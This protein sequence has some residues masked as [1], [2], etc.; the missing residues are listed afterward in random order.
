[1]KNSSRLFAKMARN[2]TRSRSGFDSSRASSSTRRLK[3]SQEISR[4]KNRGS[5]AKTSFRAPL[6]PA[7]A[8]RAALAAG[9][10]F[11][12]P[13]AS[14]RDTPS[15]GSSSPRA[16]IGFSSEAPTPPLPSKV[17]EGRFSFAS[18][19]MVPLSSG[20]PSFR[21]LPTGALYPLV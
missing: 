19:P 18:S 13:P 2:F 11:V 1:M 4:L 12:S 8:G 21:S 17:P 20:G 3:W 5:S 16:G 9:G 7:G 6:R 10:A 15:R 14:G